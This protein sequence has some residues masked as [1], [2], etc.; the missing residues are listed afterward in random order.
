MALIVTL[1]NGMEFY[2]NGVK[3]RS[4][5]NGKI[6]IEEACHFLRG[7]DMLESRPGDCSPEWQL[8]VDWQEWLAGLSTDEGQIVELRQQVRE[9]VGDV[10]GSKSDYGLLR[11]LW[12]VIPELI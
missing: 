1:S 7:G 9:R 11:S 2:F 6:A 8:H 3:C 12:R 10:T 5:T 4:L